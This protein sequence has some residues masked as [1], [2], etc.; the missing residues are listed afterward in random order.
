MKGDKIM[1]KASDYMKIHYTTMYNRN[2]KEDIKIAFLGDLHI[3]KLVNKE[4]TEYLNY[5]LQRQQPDYICYLGDIVDTP[6][7]LK[8][9]DKKEQLISVIEGSS[10]IA[11]TFAILGSHDFAN[12]SCEPPVEEE[13]KDFW[14]HLS[15]I[16]NFH[17]LVDSTYFD[18]KIFIMGYKQKMD[19]YY[20]LVKEH[21]EDLN[22]FYQDLSKRKELLE[23][24]P[25]NVPK[26]GLLHS[27][28]YARSTDNIN[29]LKE[30]DLLVS[31]HYHNG[32][33]P[34]VLD[35]MYQGDKGLISPKKQLFPSYARG[36]QMLPTRS[37]LLVNGGITKIQDC[38]PKVLQPLNSLCYQDLDIVTLTNDMD[39]LPPERVSEKVYT[40]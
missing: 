13:N 8:K 20:N 5:Q 25:Y 34:A 9:E 2:A 14:E 3:S 23:N 21:K 6:Q 4:K 29:L 37:Q 30:Y 1:R 16:N 17:L 39:Y 40:K 28:E 11:P 18:G 10:K 38:A 15:S 24:L 35:D 27:P 32:C 7:E 26:I 36:L 22:A 12:E 33:I 19:C 31:G